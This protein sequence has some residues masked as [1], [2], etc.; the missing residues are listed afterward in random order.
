MTIQWRKKTTMASF[1]HNTFVS[2]LKQYS[3]TSLRNVLLING[4]SSGI[5]AI[6][7]IALPKMI[8]DL[9]QVPRASFFFA[10]GI[11]LFA[12]ALLV[13]YEGGKDKARPGRVRLIIALDFLWVVASIIVVLAMLHTISPIGHL[14]IFVVAIWVGVMAYLQ[15]RGLNHLIN[16]KSL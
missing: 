14:L 6:G 1:K 10:V 4:A 7:L 9:F 8:A 15:V 11:F 13:L 5:T 16:K 2:S 3:M 12:F